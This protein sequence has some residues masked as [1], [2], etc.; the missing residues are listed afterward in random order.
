MVTIRTGYVELEVSVGVQGHAFAPKGMPGAAGI[1]LRLT[2]AISTGRARFRRGGYR[3]ATAGLP[4]RNSR[5][6]TRPA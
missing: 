4:A 1:R 6:S 2:T 3:Y 5:P